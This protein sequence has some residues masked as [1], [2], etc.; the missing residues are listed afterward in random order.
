[1]L[2]LHMCIPKDKPKKKMRTVL[3]GI[4]A[5]HGEDRQPSNSAKPVNTD[6]STIM[7]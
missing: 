3:E 1:M 6:P 2:Y 4:I 7:Q 5:R